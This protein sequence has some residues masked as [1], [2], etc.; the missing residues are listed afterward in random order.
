MAWFSRLKTDGPERVAAGRSTSR[1]A[2]KALTGNE[3]ALVIRSEL[4]ARW[5]NPRSVLT[6]EEALEV[7][8]RATG[9]PVGHAWVNTPTGWRTGAWFDA[10]TNGVTDISPDVYAKLRDCTTCTDLGSGRGIVAAVLYLEA[11]RFLPGLE[12][13]GSTLRHREAAA[14]GL[15]GVV[16]VPVRTQG[17]LTT[18]FEFAT[19][20]MVDADSSLAE[21]LVEVADRS[22]R[23][24][25]V[26]KTELS[27][28]LKSRFEAEFPQHLAV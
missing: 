10:G 2:A 23:R 20:Q 22:R 19:L 7:I 28:K 14:V 18:I 21:A 15:V 17:K 11:C 16:G 3:A 5:P 9:W 8:C 13:L 1:N 26:R 4:A 12:G 24:L 27:D 25:P 6:Y